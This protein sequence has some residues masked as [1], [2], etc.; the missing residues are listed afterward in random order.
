MRGE[1]DGFTRYSERKRVFLSPETLPGSDKRKTPRN[2]EKFRDELSITRGATR[3]ESGADRVPLL[4][5][6]N[7][8]ATRD[9][10]AASV[11]ALPTPLNALSVAARTP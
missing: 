3:I 9:G 5:L 10:L 1:T 8:A 11:P 6:L 7:C 4:P 2:C